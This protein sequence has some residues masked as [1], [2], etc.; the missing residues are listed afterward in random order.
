MASVV[1]DRGDQLGPNNIAARWWQ[2]GCSVIPIKADG[3][4]SPM[5][6]WKNYQKLGADLATVKNW[7][8]DLW[9]RAGVA[10]I[11]GQVSGNLEMLELEGRANTE[12]VLRDIED[13]CV[14]AGIRSLWDRLTTEGYTELTPSGG[15]HLLYRVT[16]HPV[17]GNEKVA[18]R[19]AQD[20]ELNDQEIQL[21]SQS[22]NWRPTRVLA[23][24]RGDG[25]YVIVAPTAGNCHPTG[26]AWVTLTGS[27]DSML[28]ITW[29]ERCLLH[30]VIRTVLHVPQQEPQLEIS[31][32]RVVVERDPNAP[33][34][35]VEDFNER[36]SW[37]EGWFTEQGWRV[38]HQDGNEI[39]WVRPG[40]DWGDGH[41][42]T[43]GVRDGGQDCLY[44]WSTSTGLPV[45][46]PLTKFMIYAHY[47]FNGDRSAAARELRSRGFGAPAIP[48]LQPLS[49][50]DFLPREDNASP[51]TLQRHSLEILHQDF[52]GREAMT[53]TG[54]AGRV[55]E[56]SI[57]HLRYVTTRKEWYVWH[58][59]SGTWEPD[60]ECIADRVVTEEARRTY[61][62]V[63]KL[64]E[65][66]SEPEKLKSLAKKAQSYLDDSKHKA[67]VSK[68][69][70]A[71][72][73]AISHVVFDLNLDLL[74]L[75]NGTLNLNTFEL[76]PHDPNDLSTMC[77]NA[78]YD[79]SAECP[80]FLKYLNDVVPDPDI[81][82]YLQR[83]IGYSLLGRPTKRAFFILHG[84][85]GTGKSVFTSVFTELFGSYGTTASSGTFRKPQQSD[86]PFD[87]H[88]FRDKRFISGSE[89]A[90]N[91]D[92]NENL[93]K[94]L[95]GDGDRMRTRD[96]YEKNTEWDPR[97]VIWLATN[98]LPRL[99]SDD[100]AIWRRVRTIPMKVVVK[101]QK[102][103]IG[104]Y[105]SI[106]IQEA[107]GLLNW[108]LAGLKDFRRLDGLAE[109]PVIEKDIA[110]YRNDSDSV[111]S[112]YTSIL[113][114][115][116]YR[117]DPAGRTPAYDAYMEYKTYCTDNGLGAFGNRRFT[118][119]IKG[120]NPSLE[121]ARSGGRNWINGLARE[122]GLRP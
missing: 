20:D 112:W 121:C 49:D 48:P 34:T 78:A 15:L 107:N 9:P 21:R 42:A 75:Q 53:D 60:T 27:P 89:L 67:V 6:P 55:R 58:S 66:Q 87:V 37:H 83:A 81:R 68:L 14:A 23:E 119:R 117:E 59:G 50:D 45:E 101:N 110:N 77:F 85:S 105:H 102:E 103:E 84:P 98:H 56:R 47:K 94:R 71:P 99:T 8:E 3:T 33:L 40:K 32:P 46:V 76:K 13:A 12:N 29:E 74:T 22:P 91:L 61:D 39:F 92:F 70:S 95:C 90:Q 100:D 44:V 63:L 96:L 120:I 16:D 11:C 111:M 97:C 38:H 113:A 115:G 5:V 35:P 18:S 88:G 10:V 109:P 62:F 104:G 4:K 82:E 43:T 106:L 93:V 73:L 17:P 19:P 65:R 7:F 122:G 24:T 52:T 79:P 57:N 69:R 51:K 1:A 86:N 30:Q 28:N 80:N 25:G 118:S 54:Y 26:L 116:V 114:D 108:A 72:G 36:A 41:S 31:G 2:G 64:Q